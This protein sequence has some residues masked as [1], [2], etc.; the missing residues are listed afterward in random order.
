MGRAFIERVRARRH[1]HHAEALRRQRRRGRARQLSDRSQRAACSTERYFPP[2]DAAITAGRRA[3]GDD[4]LQLGGRLAGDAESRGCSTACSKRDWGF[5]GFVISDAAATGGATVLHMTEPNTPTAAQHAFEAGPRRRL[6]VVVRPQQRPYLDA[7]QRGLIA[8]AGRSTP[9]SR[10]CCARS[11]SSACSSSRTSTPTAPRT[12]NGHA[13]H[14]ALAR[15]AARGVDGA[16]AQRARHA[17]AVPRRCAS[18]AVIGADATEAR[19]GGYSGPG[20]KQGLDPRRHPRE[21]R[22]RRASRYAPGPGRADR[23]SSST[24][25]AGVPASAD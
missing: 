20:V 12:S 13:D 8:D 5:T 9:P 22:R 15:E 21:A 10:A 18:V 23:A 7:F 3:L 16:A 19:L 24:V 2:F 14:R 1:R 17:A 11:S 4:G 25:P 6:S